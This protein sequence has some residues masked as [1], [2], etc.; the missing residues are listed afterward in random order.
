MKLKR[1]RIALMQASG[2]TRVLIASLAMEIA[3]CWNEQTC[4]AAVP[5]TV[6]AL[7]FRQATWIE[8][9]R[10]F[11]KNGWRIAPIEPTRSLTFAG[12]GFLFMQV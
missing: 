7:R 12:P 11:Q 1:T 8:A 6:D 9:F 4:S 5:L 10:L 2:Q 3:R